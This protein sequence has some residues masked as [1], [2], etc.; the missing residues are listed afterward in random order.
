MA[1]DAA[2]LYARTPRRARLPVLTF[3]LVAV[4]AI[5]ITGVQNVDWVLLVLILVAAI[6][7]VIAANWIQTRTLVPQFVALLTG[8]RSMHTYVY[9]AS[10]QSDSMDVVLHDSVY[11]R[12]HFSSI[13][14]V[15]QSA[16]IIVV[17]S[18]GG[19][20]RL[21]PRALVPDEWF[22]ALRSAGV[23]VHT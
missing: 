20:I 4:M 9:A 18:L 5:A 7:T 12:L 2:R 21:I 6:P 10:V 11:E 22:D 19:A 23:R 1:R 14:R 8:D 16:S 13:S 3:A 17:R 15:D